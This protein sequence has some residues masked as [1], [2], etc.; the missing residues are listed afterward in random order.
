V[1]RLRILALLVALTAVLVG[2]LGASTAAAGSTDQVRERYVRYA[3]IRERL[4]ACSLDRTWQHLGS[5][6]RKRCRT[7]R[8]QYLLYGLNGESGTFYFYCRK[9]AK[10]CPSAPNGARNPRTPPPANATLFR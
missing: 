1:T 4:K 10:S 3:L 7:L 2:T 8:R 9:R 6:A 5:S